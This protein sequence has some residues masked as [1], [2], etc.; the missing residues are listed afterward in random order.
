MEIKNQNI[1]STKRVLIC[2]IDIDTLN[3]I[4]IS[5]NNITA[6][7]KTLT[8]NNHILNSSFWFANDFVIEI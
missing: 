8:D 6:L 5:K 3:G 7:T 2:N 1:I 4:T